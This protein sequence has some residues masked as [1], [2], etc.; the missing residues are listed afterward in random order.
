MEERGIGRFKRGLVFL[1]SVCFLI[2]VTWKYN[3]SLN[4]QITVIQEDIV[5]HDLPE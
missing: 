3:E 4:N 2:T 5:I 1:L